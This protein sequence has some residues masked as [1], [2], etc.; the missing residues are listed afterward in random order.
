MCKICSNIKVKTPVS[1]LKALNRLDILFWC[2]YVNFE[3]FNT[4]WVIVVCCQQKYWYFQFK[5]Y[6]SLNHDG[7]TAIWGGESKTT[8]NLLQESTES[9]SSGNIFQIWR[10]YGEIS[11]CQWCTDIWLHQNLFQKKRRRQRN[12][13]YQPKAHIWL[14]SGNLHRKDIRIII[15]LKTT[16]H[17]EILLN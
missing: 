9:F 12:H 1:L 13:G 15:I 8:W 10:I 4:G 5:G 16:I 2:F 17:E 6:N 11:Y 7:N 3:W 14:N